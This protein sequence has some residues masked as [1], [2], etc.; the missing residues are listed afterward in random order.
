MYLHPTLPLISCYM[1]NFFIRA[2]VDSRRW[3]ILA[4]EGFDLFPTFTYTAP[5]GSSSS[6]SSSRSSSS[7]GSAAVRSG[8]TGGGPPYTRSSPPGAE[9]ASDDGSS[10]GAP[11][12]TPR[13][14]EAAVASAGGRSHI[15][16]M[17]VLDRLAPIPAPRG[18][19]S[20]AGLDP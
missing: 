12:L 1:V 18:G 5:A 6:S 14:A 9:G 3:R 10:G 2:L 13:A 4:A 20:E 19:S 8:S 7:I 11:S 16:T 17:V 15:E